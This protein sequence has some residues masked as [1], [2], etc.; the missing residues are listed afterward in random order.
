[1]SPE[2]QRIAI[3]E[4]CGWTYQPTEEDWKWFD[5]EGEGYRYCPDYLSD[6]NAMHDAWLKLTDQQR[7][8]FR[9]E[10]SIIAHREGTW[11]EIA[12]AKFGTEAFLKTI[13]KWED[14]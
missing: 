14:A 1:M 13:G 5:K 8:V 11:T 9:S 10:L 12:M 2:R 4:A 7:F 3:A 6:L